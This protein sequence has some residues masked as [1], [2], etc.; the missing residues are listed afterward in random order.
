M[1]TILRTLSLVA[2]FFSML[3]LSACAPAGATSADQL[4][5]IATTSILADVVR[6]VGG[7]HVNV[8]S[9][10]PPG[11]NEHEY[12]P[13]ARDIA[14]VVDADL[15]F[16]VGLGLEEFMST[17]IQNAGTEVSVVTVSEGI[18]PQQFQP[19]AGQ[20]LLDSHT[21]GDPHVWMDPANV[22]TWGQ[23]IATALIAW[24]P[25]H[26]SDYKANLAA[27]TASLQEL[28]NWIV[29]QI[30]TIPADQRK[31]VTDHM[32]FG[33]FTQKY[34]LEVV[35]AVIPSYSSSA[36]PSARDL[37][38]LEDAIR[39]Y[40]VNAILVGNTVNPALSKQVA[41]DTGVRMV[42]FYTGS[43][44]A[45]D[46]PAATYIDYMHYNVNAIVSALGGE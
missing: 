33:Y 7:T 3:P 23:N 22:V 41:A 6:Q 17:L 13:A 5:V 34:G 12:Q 9:L 18:T 31:I 14:A 26:E 36:A 4:Q 24:D 35:G 2:L 27:Y 29:G 20:G 38:A 8:N 11:G 44:S 25:Q 46:G 21:S 43:L 45:A 16:E 1:K 28:D 10:V 37:A 39:Q 19:D 42:Q 32:L 15:V 40:D 30:A